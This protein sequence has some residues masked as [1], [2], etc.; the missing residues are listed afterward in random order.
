VALGCDYPTAHMII[1][2]NIPSTSRGKLV[3][4]AF[5]FQAVGALAGTALGYAVLVIKPD[6]DAWRWMYTTAVVPALLV[7][8]GRFYVTESANWLRGRGH[9]AAEAHPAV[10][11][12]YRVVAASRVR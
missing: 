11:K 5:A 10:S 9:P 7:T 3:L 6:L 12:P 8:I 4:G 2:E 1:S